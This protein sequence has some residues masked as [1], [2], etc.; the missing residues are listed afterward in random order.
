MYKKL[1]NPCKEMLEKGLCLGCNKLELESFEGEE[2]CVYVRNIKND[3]ICN[4]SISG[5][6]MYYDTTLYSI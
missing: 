3:G 2:N 5:N 6:Y 1:K 4:N